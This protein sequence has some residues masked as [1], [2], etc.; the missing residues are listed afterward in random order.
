M[1]AGG[2]TGSPVQRILIVK[3][4]S[5]GD[6]VHA[7]AALQDI[8]AALPHA[9][10]DWVVERAFA[11]LVTRC[12]GVHAVIACDLRR[13]RHH[14]LARQTLLDWRSFK[15]ALQAQRYDAVIDLQGLTKSGVVAWLARKTP[16]GRHF[17]LANRTE[18]SSYEAPSRWLADVA[19][20]LPPH[21]HAVERSRQICAAAL[22]YRPVGEPRFG[23][24]GAAAAVAERPLVLLAHGTSRADKEWPQGHWVALGQQLNAAGWAVAL[25]HGNARELARSEAIASQLSQAVVWPAVAIDAVVD[26][27]AG[28]AGVIGVD[29]GLSHMAVAL[30]LAHVQIYNFDNAWRTGVNVARQVTVY[31]EPWPDVAQV[32]QA[33]QRVA[34]AHQSA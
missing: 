10:I 21:V 20:T 25:A 23:L 19:V 26:A 22:G 24:Q 4:S 11:P 28:C 1:I 30:G 13:W 27:M 32:W 16:N 15:S 3:L 33:W 29:S 34:Q 18:G 2:V 7:L 5:L 6:V 14:P 9:Q 31:A 8:R 12:S 17:G